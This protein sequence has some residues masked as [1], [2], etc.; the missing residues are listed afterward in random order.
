MDLKC[1]VCLRDISLCFAKPSGCD[2]KDFCSQCLCK[3]EEM[4]IATVSPDVRSAE[5]NLTS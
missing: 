3:I 5:E 1:S 4:A 2:H